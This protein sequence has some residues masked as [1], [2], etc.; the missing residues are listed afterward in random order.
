MTE[1]PS[2]DFIPYIQTRCPTINELDAELAV[3]E[4][5]IAF[6]KDSKLF[7]HVVEITGQ[8]CITEYVLDIPED[9][10]LI[11]ITFEGVKKKDRVI[12]DWW[13]DDGY[14][15]IAIPNLRDGDCV[16]VEYLYHI[17]RNNCGIPKMIFDKYL[18]TIVDR[19]IM[20]LFT[21]DQ[22]GGVA[23]GLFGLCNASY[24]A[25]I[26]EIKARRMHNMSNKLVRMRLPQ[27]RR[28]R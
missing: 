20:F 9:Q 13:R 3:R 18:N 22:S 21:S 24:D 28:G 25:A 26:A 16:S 14:D 19:A 2:D 7:R 8:K 17:S 12:D 15:A 6:M 11:D 27:Q 10:V 4:A 23:P 5:V 1:V